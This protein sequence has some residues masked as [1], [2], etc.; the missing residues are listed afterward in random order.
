MN[1]DPAGI[2]LLLDYQPG[3]GSCGWHPGMGTLGGPP[4]SNVVTETGPAGRAL[5][6]Q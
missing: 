2:T 1:I 6:S 3:S 4:N 5:H